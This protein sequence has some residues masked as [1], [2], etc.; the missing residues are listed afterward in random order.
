VSV[1]NNAERRA[2][3][4]QNRTTGRRLAGEMNMRTLSGC[5]GDV[6]SAGIP[7]GRLTEAGVDSSS[8]AVAGNVAH[9]ASHVFFMEKM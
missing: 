9:L 7:V 2:A 3:L 6:G 4:Q 1:K 5:G 8:S